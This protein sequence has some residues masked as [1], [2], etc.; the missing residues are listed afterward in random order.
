MSVAIWPL[1]SSTLRSVSDIK[2]RRIDIIAEPGFASGVK[3]LDLDELRHRRDMCAELDIELS[4]YRRM[5]HGKMDLLAYEMRRRAGE[6]TMSIIEA[7]PRIMAE[8]GYS[9][10]GPSQRSVPV[11]IP[12]LPEPGRRLVDRALGDDYLLRLPS[13][14]DDELR[15]TQNFLS[16]VEVDVSQQRK[17]V[18]AVLDRFQEELARRYR[19][20]AGQSEPAADE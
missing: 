4:Y 3:G 1:A 19:V 5:L 6:E 17:Q 11:E 16:E 12:D 7:L 15:D 8:G 13:M 2:R 9:E 10:S 18:H 14:T 20:D